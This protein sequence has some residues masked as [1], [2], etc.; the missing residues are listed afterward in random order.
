MHT[1]VLQVFGPTNINGE[2]AYITEKDTLDKCLGH[3]G[4][5]VDVSEQHQCCKQQHS[6]C[7][8]KLPPHKMLHDAHAHGRS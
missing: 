3:A 5:L 4:A 7:P 6:A 8:R 2:D 1:V